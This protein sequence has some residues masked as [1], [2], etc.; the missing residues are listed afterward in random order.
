M[1]TRR[2]GRKSRRGGEGDNVSAESPSADVAAVQAPVQA[3]ATN[4]QPAVQPPVPKPQCPQE[5]IAKGCGKR[6]I[7]HKIFG[8]SGGRKSRRGGRKSRRGGRKSRRGGR[9]SRR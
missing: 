9:K 7:L 5:C 1:D 8:M 3:P 6:N 4:K 2:G